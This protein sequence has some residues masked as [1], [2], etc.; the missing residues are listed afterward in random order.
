MRDVYKNESMR[1]KR[2]AKRS[3]V[4]PSIAV[5]T[6]IKTGALLKSKFTGIIRGLNLLLPLL[7]FIGQ[8]TR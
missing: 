7:S 1:R 4:S 5:K 3:S 8:E 2:S 6:V